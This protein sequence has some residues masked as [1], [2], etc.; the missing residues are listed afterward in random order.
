MVVWA[1]TLM[2]AASSIKSNELYNGKVRKVEYNWGRATI[3]QGIKKL[4][5]GFECVGN[6]KMR[7]N[8]KTEEKP[9]PYQTG[10]SRNRRTP[11]SG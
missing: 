5:S 9:P 6:L 7:G 1:V 3:S 8:K 11:L 2:S 10:Y 4:S